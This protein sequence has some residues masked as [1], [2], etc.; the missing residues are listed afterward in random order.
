MKSGGGLRGVLENSRPQRVVKISLTSFRLS[1][2][3]YLRLV[4][5]KESQQQQWSTAKEILHP[6]TPLP[7]LPE[8]C[9]T[10][11]TYRW[12]SCSLT[13]TYTHIRVTYMK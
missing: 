10:L 6:H 1:G 4:K 7:L 12:P 2:H 5:G 9:S 8:H 13:H 3:R 11:S